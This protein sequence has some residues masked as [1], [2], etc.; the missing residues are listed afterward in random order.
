MKFDCIHYWYL[1]QLQGLLKHE[2]K[3]KF[4]EAYQEWQTNPANFSIDGNYPVRQL[5]ERARNC[6]D[7][8]LLHD[9]RSVLVVAHNAVNQALIATAIGTCPLFNELTSK[10]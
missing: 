2:G 6:W 8:I 10:L 5:W 1:Y 4:G 3:E 9:S 7:K